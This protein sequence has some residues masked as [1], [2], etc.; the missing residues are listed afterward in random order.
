M[1][2]FIVNWVQ[3]FTIA[4]QK[5]YNT[6]YI[7]CSTKLRLGNYKLFSMRKIY[8]Q[9]FEKLESYIFYKNETMKTLMHM[10]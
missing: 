6:Y 10:G 8:K 1:V 3:F 2:P 9:C 5:R 4:C 7:H